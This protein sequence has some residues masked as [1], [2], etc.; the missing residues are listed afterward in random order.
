MIPKVSRLLPK[1]SHIPPQFFNAIFVMG[2]FDHQGEISVGIFNTG[3]LCH[4]FV[5]AVA[6]ILFGLLYRSNQKG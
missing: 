2:P 1:N 5:C 3:N 4:F 6:D